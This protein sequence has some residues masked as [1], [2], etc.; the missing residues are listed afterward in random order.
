VYILSCGK[1]KAVRAY[2]VSAPAKWGEKIEGAPVLLAHVSDYHYCPVRVREDGEW[3]YV[4]ATAEERNDPHKRQKST[5]VADPRLIIQTRGKVAEA[6]EFESARRIHRHEFPE[7]THNLSERHGTMVSSNDP[8]SQRHSSAPRP[9]G[10]SQD[11]NH[12]GRQR[13]DGDQRKEDRERE[14]TEPNNDSFLQER[15]PTDPR[16]QGRISQSQQRPEGM[17]VDELSV[18]IEERR[19]A[20]P[21]LDAPC[22]LGRTQHFEQRPK[23]TQGVEGWDDGL[24]AIEVGMRAMGLVEVVEE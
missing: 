22:F 4:L 13:K 16:L 15:M 2:D 18:F 11:L 19:P 8:P 1:D 5:F 6:R 7:D 17:N 9:E 3:A 12:Q 24:E 10:V 21:F 23:S 20:Q 14:K